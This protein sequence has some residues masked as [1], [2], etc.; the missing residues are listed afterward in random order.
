MEGFKFIKD[1]FDTY[2][3]KYRTQYEEIKTKFEQL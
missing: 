2:D 1:Y 3:N